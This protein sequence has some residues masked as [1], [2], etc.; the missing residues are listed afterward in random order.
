MAEI[1]SIADL[2][3]LLATRRQ[4]FDIARLF[5]ASTTAAG[6][7]WSGWVQSGDPPTGVAP[8][9]TPAATS[10]AT[11]GALAAW[12]DP[13]GGEIA[14][15]AEWQAACLINVQGLWLW[16]RLWHCGG[17][18]GTDVGLHSITSPA[19][20]RGD[21]N[22]EGVELFVEGYTVLGATP[23]TLTVTYTDS[24][25]NGGNVTTV[26]IPASLRAT[27]ILPIDLLTGDRGVKSVE[28]FQLGGSTGSVGSF[29]LT[30]GRRI[31]AI[32]PKLATET[33]IRRVFEMGFPRLSAGA[34]LWL[35]ASTLAS[36]GSTDMLGSLAITTSG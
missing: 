4:V 6:Q 28:S 33:E 19:I 32:T 21:T 1:T 15:L 13:S 12:H 3:T 30:A 23:Q 20:T 22:G 10:S 24:D 35:T 14:H 9:T 18:S 29:G 5:S 2:N 7:E 31:C 11:A 17:F 25:S 16:D 26:T 27:R 34:C 8:T 36:S